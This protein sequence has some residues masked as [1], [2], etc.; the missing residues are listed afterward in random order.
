MDMEYT[1]SPAPHN[2]N[3]LNFMD[4]EW[5]VILYPLLVRILY[6]GRRWC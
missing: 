5:Q 6:N 4:D 2:C 3:P 1:I